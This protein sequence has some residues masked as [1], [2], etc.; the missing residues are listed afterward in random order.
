MICRFLIPVALL[1]TP[2]LAAERSFTVENFDRL[3]VAGPHDVEVRVGGKPSVRAFG[4]PEDLD[5]LKIETMR[6]RLEIG[7]KSKGWGWG[8]RDG[9]ATS[10]L[11]LLVTAP[12]LREVSLA[13]SGNVGVDHI[14]GSALKADIAGSGSLRL[15]MVEAKRVEASIAGSGSIVAAGR[16]GT[17]VANIAGSGD[18]R[19]GGLACKTLDANIAGSGNIEARTTATAD[20]SIMGSG[21]VRVTGGAK[22]KVGKMGSGKAHCS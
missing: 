19:L 8:W 16:C 14:H 18:L 10:K 9:K 7:S 13:G 4:E 3:S 22:C 2:A 5:R 17:L 1:S 15:G 12:S 21:D 6:G 11:R 20:I